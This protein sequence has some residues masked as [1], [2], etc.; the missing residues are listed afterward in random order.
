MTGISNW[1]AWLAFAHDVWRSCAR[2]GVDLLA[3]RS[4][5]CRA[6]YRSEM[7]R[8]L[9]LDPAAAGGDLPGLRPLSRAVALREPRRPASASCFRP[10][11]GAMLI[12]LVLVMLQLQ[13][14]V[15]RSVLVLYPIVLIF[16][17]AGSRFAYRIWKEHRLY[18]PLAALGE[19][20]LVVGAGDAGA[21][22]T[23]SSRAAGSGASSGLLDDDPA[24]QGRQLRN[25]RGAGPDRRARAA[26]RDRYGV[27]KVIIALPSTN[28]AVRRRVAELC[29]AAGIEALT[30]PSY[31][32]L[33]SGRSA[34]TDDP[35]RRARRPPRPRPGRARQRRAGRVA[36]QSRRDG[37]R[38]RRL[39]RRRAVP[40]DRPLPARASSCCSTSRKPRSTR[41]APCS[42]TRSRSFRWSHAS[43]ATSS[44]R[45][46]SRRCSTREKPD[47]DLPRGGVQARAADGGDQRLVRRCATTPTAPGCSR[48]R[49]WRRRSRSSCSCRPT[50]RS[51]RRRS[52][53]RPSASPRSSAR[54][55]SGAAHAVRHRAL[56]Q[57]VR[58]RRQRDPALSRADR[59]RRAGHRHAP[60]HHALLHV[61]VRGDAAA[62]A[63]RP[64]GRERRDPRARHGRA[65]AHRRP[66]ARH[67]QALRRRSGPHRDRVHRPAARRE[68]LR[69]AARVRGGDEADAASEAAASRRRARATATRC[70]RW[71]RGASAI[72]RPTM[73]RCARGSRPGF[74]STRRSRARRSRRFRRPPP[75]RSTRRCRC[76]RRG[77]ADRIAPQS[78]A[79]ARAPSASRIA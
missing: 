6:P 38:R 24:K 47:V 40:A 77:G 7:L 59:A 46:W 3:A 50:R 56:R 66:R 37:H 23:R 31:E 9:A 69:G 65:G 72:A 41:S 52:W 68:A 76:G 55:C 73:P 78:R 35:Q 13:A 17:M 42:P 25:V 26:G 60:G 1:R 11:L 19:P 54:A 64:A 29:A 67:D 20:V 10:C 30:V 75:T 61:A 58:Q 43:S 51:T 34:L 63:G 33:I 8:T 2:V 70:G 27:R 48:A 79:G 44:T 18:S 53:A 12:P 22:L 71:S 62:A 4:L 57:R 16:L 21:R 49:R 14:V 32:D 45:R 15:P 36:R 74:R 39:D 5:D 28:H